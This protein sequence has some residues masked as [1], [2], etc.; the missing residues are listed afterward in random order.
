MDFNNN[1]TEETK[2]EETKTEGFDASE[3]VS[4]VKTYSQ[5]LLLYARL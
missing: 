5:V 1:K 2:A 3:T 4:E